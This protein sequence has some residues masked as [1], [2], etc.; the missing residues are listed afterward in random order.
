LRRMTGMPDYLPVM[1]DCERALGRP[2]AA[3]KLAKEARG[4]TLDP[5][6]QIE[7]TIVEAGARADLGQ[8]AE[9]LRLLDQAVTRVGN[10]GA[11]LAPA[12]ARLRYAYADALLAAEEEAEARRWFASAAEI[13]VDGVTDADE[14]RDRLDGLLIDFDEAEDDAEVANQDQNEHQNEHH[15][16]HDHEHQDEHRDAGGDGPARP[17]GPARS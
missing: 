7:M 2:H 10:R 3:I 9:G 11:G 8:S 13:D 4:L 15:H 14:R 12:V 1:A 17:T 5:A 16:E 6:L